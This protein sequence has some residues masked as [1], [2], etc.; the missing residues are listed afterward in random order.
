MKSMLRMALIFKYHKNLFPITV[1]IR[2]KKSQILRFWETSARNI[3]FKLFL[4]AKKPKPVFCYF[5][6]IHGAFW[7]TLSITADFLFRLYSLDNNLE[8]VS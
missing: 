8:H 1:N 5:Q 2:N 4:K 6:H 7:N 3:D